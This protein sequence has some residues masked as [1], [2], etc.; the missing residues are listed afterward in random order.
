MAFNPGPTAFIDAGD[1]I[2][3]MENRK[4]WHVCLKCS[5]SLLPLE[6]VQNIFAS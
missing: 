1:V 5:Y 4:K 2:V 6:I 3:A